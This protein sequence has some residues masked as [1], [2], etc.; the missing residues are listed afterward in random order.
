MARNAIVESVPAV[1][2]LGRVCRESKYERT[3][4]DVHSLGRLRSRGRGWARDAAQ[5]FRARPRSFADRQFDAGGADFAG[6][7]P[8]PGDTQELSGPRPG[9][10][11]R[12][13]RRGAVRRSFLERSARSRRRRI[14]AR[15]DPLRERGDLRGLVR[16]GERRPLPSR[17]KP[18]A[19]LHERDRRLRTPRDELQPR[20]RPHAA[21]ARAARHGSAAFAA[22]GVGIAGAA[23]RAVRR[24]RRRAARKT[25]RSIRAAFPSTKLVPSAAPARA[26]QASPS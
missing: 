14:E 10:A 17:A 22:H 15:E 7:H 21:A 25:C 5:T 3:A 13:T 19:S 12:R 24:L 8:A 11:Y 6:A 9:R 1:Y 26:R 2:P 20:R 23:L 4:A 18:G 16:L